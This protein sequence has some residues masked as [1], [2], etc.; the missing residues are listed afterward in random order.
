MI[1]TNFK[2]IVQYVTVALL[3]CC[4]LTFVTHAQTTSTPSTSAAVSTPATPKAVSIQERVRAFDTAFF[5]AFNT[6]DLATLE[7]MVSPDL[8]FFHD[9]AGTSRTR[10]TFLD[11]VKNNVCGKF[12][13]AL[14]TKTFEVWPLGKEGA[15]YSGSHQ[16]CHAGKAGCQ[17]EGRFLHVLEE[18]NG[19][20]MLLRVVSY[21]HREITAAH[22]TK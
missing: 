1:T 18:R 3:L 5:N 8:E 7:R 22:S 19:Q 13:R 10:A 21:D 11:S 4:G 9:L 14:L 15:I 6:C 20:L 16:F 2:H 17:G 12:A